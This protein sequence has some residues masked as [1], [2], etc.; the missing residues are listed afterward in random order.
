MLWRVFPSLSLSEWIWL[1][2]MWKQAKK[3][4]LTLVYQS[5][6]SNPFLHQQSTGLEVNGESWVTQSAVVQRTCDCWSYIYQAQANQIWRFTRKN[7]AT[8]KHSRYCS[9][10]YLFPWCFLGC[11]Y[12]E[13]HIMWLTKTKN[14]L[15]INSFKYFHQFTDNIW[16][17]A[18][19][20]S[21]ERHCQ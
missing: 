15:C 5:A 4:L 10:L 1:G 17:S 21:T 18:P 12:S 13:D 19:I 9:T 11:L 7:V 14:I 6:L 2:L 8:E 16:Y 20:Q 3:M